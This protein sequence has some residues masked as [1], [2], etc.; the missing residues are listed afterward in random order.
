METIVL[1]G[2]SKANMKLILEFAQKLGVSARKLSNSEIEDI[3]L[4][5]AIEEGASGEYI[6]TNEFLNKLRRK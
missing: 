4:I 3:S 5:K 6:D 2:K 1:S